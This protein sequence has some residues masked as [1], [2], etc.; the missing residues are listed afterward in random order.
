[1]CISYC[2]A[3][4]LCGYPYNEKTVDLIF[5][6]NDGVKVLAL[7]RFCHEKD[8]TYHKRIVFYMEHKTDYPAIVLSGVH[9]LKLVCSASSNVL[10]ATL[11]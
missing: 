8:E 10:N 3:G 11:E 6:I 5:L 1:M 9:R 7:I 4:A 2:T